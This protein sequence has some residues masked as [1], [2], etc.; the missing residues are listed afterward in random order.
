VRTRSL[1]LLMPLAALS[2]AACG[3]D[4]SGSSNSGST[5]ANTAAA[6][7][8]AADTAA[9]DTAAAAGATTLQLASSTLGTILVDSDGNTLYLF[10]NDAPN[11][12]RCDTGC[13]GIW[14]ALISDGATTVGE[15]LSLDDVGTVTAADGS[16]Q[17]TFY[18]HPLYSFA[19]DAA[20]GD[21]NG[22]GIGGVWYVL[23]AEGNAVK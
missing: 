10:G 3:D 9:A 1:L 11:A 16:T 5:A 15:G 12:P 7:T 22:Q 19:G 20:P 2:L 14:P 21:V 13:L 6:D 8:A 17:V 23:D 18:G 4:S